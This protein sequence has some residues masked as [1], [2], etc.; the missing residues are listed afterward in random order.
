MKKLDFLVG[1]WAG[2][3]RITRGAG[4]TTELVQTEEAGY[5]LDGLIL[6]IEGIGSTKSGGAPALQAFGVISYDDDT[7]TYHMRAF[8][9]GRFLETEI[10]LL[11]EG[12]GM[13]WGF[14]LGEIK[15][16]SLLRINEKGEWT[17]LHEI[18]L[19]SQPSRK[20]MEVVVRRQT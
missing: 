9:D 5:K 12:K 14:S 8:N 3:A 2:E 4:E 15:T 11:K 20:L 18:I 13:T 19:G 1:K 6:A 7:Q 10:K 17:E 16:K